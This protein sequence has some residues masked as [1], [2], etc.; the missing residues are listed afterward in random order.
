MATRRIVF[1]GQ[2]TVGDCIVDGR[3]AVR[4]VIAVW[5]ANGIESSSYLRRSISAVAILTGDTTGREKRNIERAKR[6]RY[7]APATTQPAATLC[8]ERFFARLEDK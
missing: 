4:E 7:K 2:A 6:R 8:A 5:S 3:G 1:E